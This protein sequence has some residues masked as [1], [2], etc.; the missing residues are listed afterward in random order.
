MSFLVKNCI[1]AILKKFKTFS[2]DYII[3]NYIEVMEKFD[4]MMDWL[5][6][7]YVNTLNAI[8]YMHCI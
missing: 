7:L 8:Q 3:M 6:E 1:I 2:E 5:V 4:K